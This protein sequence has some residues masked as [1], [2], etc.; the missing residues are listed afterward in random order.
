MKI[1]YL[2]NVYR[3]TLQLLILIFCLL[4]ANSDISSSIHKPRKKPFR[5]F[6]KLR[7]YIR[8][9]LQYCIGPVSFHYEFSPSYV[10]KS[11]FTTPQQDRITLPKNKTKQNPSSQISTNLYQWWRNFRLIF[12]VHHA[13]F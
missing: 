1:Q 5:K 3:S 13:Y 9:S 4:L 6:Y 2:K 10:L 11:E 7:A 8:G 12:R